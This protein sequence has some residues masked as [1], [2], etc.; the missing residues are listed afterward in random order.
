MLKISKEDGRRL[1]EKDNSV[2][3]EERLKQLDKD[4]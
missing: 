3:R 2:S 4:Q 1:T